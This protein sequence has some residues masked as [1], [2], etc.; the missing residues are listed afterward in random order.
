MEKPREQYV[1]KPL[2]TLGLK[3]KEEDTDK[4]SLTQSYSHGDKD[5]WWKVI[6]GDGQKAFWW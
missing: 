6:S 1:W 2:P 5:F 3:K 4:M